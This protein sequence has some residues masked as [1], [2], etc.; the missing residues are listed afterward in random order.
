M[1][2]LRSFRAALV[3]LFCLVFALPASVGA[4]DRP[5]NERLEKMSASWYYQVGRQALN[6]Y[7]RRAAE[8]LFLRCLELD[9]SFADCHKFLG[10][11]Y[12]GR[13]WKLRACYRF[14]KYVD[15]QPGA[16]DVPKISRLIKRSC[17]LRRR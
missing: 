8:K 14:R 11:V 16:P 17:G 15:L 4:A 10:L 9:R 12:A 3:G 1:L 5:V 2:D 6:L 7:K 13:G